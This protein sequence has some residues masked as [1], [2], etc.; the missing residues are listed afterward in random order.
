MNGIHDCGGMQGYGP[1]VREKNE[2]IFHAEWEGR[3]FGMFFALFGGG[4][5]NVDEFRW[6]I[7]RMGAVHYLESTYYEHWL[8]CYERVLD[9]KG[10]VTAAEMNTRVE[11]LKKERAN[12][13]RH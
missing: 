7:E 5:M 3:V 10:I 11:K 6:A 4:H 2:P 9:E 1:V 12:A 13:G 8:A